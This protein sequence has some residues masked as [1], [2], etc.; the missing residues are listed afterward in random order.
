VGSVAD[1]SRTY[2]NGKP[3]ILI[4]ILEFSTD[5]AL[6][7]PDL[8]EVRLCGDEHNTLASAVHTNI[9]LVYALDSHSRLT[10]CHNLISS[11]VWHDDGKWQTAVPFK[12]RR[13]RE[14]K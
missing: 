10:G 8:L 7:Q 9:T 1:I 13:A 5:Q 14:R 3:I 4:H 6:N 11:D 12:S 2:Q